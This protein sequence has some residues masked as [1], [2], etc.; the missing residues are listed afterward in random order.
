MRDYRAKQLAEN[1]TELSDA[2]RIVEAIGSTNLIFS[3]RDR[4][5]MPDE[6]LYFKTGTDRDRA[7]LLDTLLRHSAI[8]VSE[9]PQRHSF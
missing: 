8:G 6:V 1:I 2:I 7:L 5:A 4:I 9:S 3:D